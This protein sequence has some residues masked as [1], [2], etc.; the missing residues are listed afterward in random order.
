MSVFETIIV[1]FDGSKHAERVLDVA[2]AMSRDTGA[3]LVV[4]CGCAPPPA[5]WWAGPR[6]D[7]PER[8]KAETECKAGLQEAT[9]RCE[10]ACG[11]IE[12]VA[13]AEDPVDVL[14]QLATQ[15]PSPVIVIGSKARGAALGSTASGLTHRSH[16]PVLVVPPS[17]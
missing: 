8:E 7:S 15:K 13:V 4:A 10:G 6:I 17:D 14:L 2:T 16:V 11:L 5:M 1:G 9:A 3:P 12:T